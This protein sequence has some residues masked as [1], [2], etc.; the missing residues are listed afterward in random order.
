MVWSIGITSKTPPGFCQAL[1]EV[2]D[3]GPYAAGPRIA[4]GRHRGGRNRTGRDIDASE[5]PPFAF[6][7]AL[8]ATG[9]CFGWHLTDLEKGGE[10]LKSGR[11]T[12]NRR[13]FK[14]KKHRWCFHVFSV[15]KKLFAF[16]ASCSRIF[17]WVPGCCAPPSAF[18]PRPAPARRR[19]SEVVKQA[20]TKKHHMSASTLQALFVQ[21]LDVKHV[22][23]L[24]MAAA[25]SMQISDS[26]MKHS[27]QQTEGASMSHFFLLGLAPYY[28]CKPL[29]PRV[30]VSLIFWGRAVRFPVQPCRFR[31]SFV[32]TDSS[33]TR[34]HGTCMASLMMRTLTRK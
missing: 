7:V 34:G 29:K 16:S 24:S 32:S 4:F 18:R 27:I 22:K 15:F 25:A 2:F 31:S 3:G 10:I 23:H 1:L 14:Q 5:V 12:T 8:S 19:S 17:P 21:S 26:F 9:D 33:A 20:D 6:G 13:D 28:H 11:S 30:H